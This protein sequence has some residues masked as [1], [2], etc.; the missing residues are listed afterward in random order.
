MFDVIPRKFNKYNSA[1]PFGWK[2]GGEQIPKIV[3]LN[4]LP[5]TPVIGLEFRSYLPNRTFTTMIR[6]APQHLRLCIVH[7]APGFSYN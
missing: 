3:V 7:A 2:A 5:P 4:I 1:E 6:K